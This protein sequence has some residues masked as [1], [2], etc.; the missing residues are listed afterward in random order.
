MK[1]FTA[2]PGTLLGG[3][4]FGRSSARPDRRSLRA[5]LFSSLNPRNYK[6]GLIASLLVAA[7]CFAPAMLAQSPPYYSDNAWVAY[8]AA[9]GSNDLIVTGGSPG[10][11]GAGYPIT[12]QSSPLTPALT[13][14]GGKLVL[15]YVANN[16]SDDLLV[17][18]NEA[19][20]TRVTGQ[21]SGHAP[22][23][24]VFNNKLVLAYVA[25]NGSDDLLVTTSTNGVNWTPSTPVTGQSSG[26]APAL[27][28]FDNKLVLAYVANNGSDD[29]LV[30]TSTN[31]VNWTP[32]TPVTGQ[33]SAQ[34]PSLT[35]FDNKLVL[36]YVAN[37]GS[38]DLLVTTSTNSV[39][40]TPSTPVTGQT[41]GLS[42]A[43][44]VIANPNVSY[45]QFTTFNLIMVYVADN[46]SDDLIVTTSA[47]GIHWTTGTR[48]TGQSSRATPAIV[49]TEQFND[50]IP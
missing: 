38:D 28:V 23:L 22:A 29:L 25:N 34:P 6:T 44:S 12:G 49:V 46:G 8:I 9:N 45:T 14:F 39:N 41:S 15:A 13:V 20:S 30:T 5:S 37:N 7:A 43:L 4:P 50:T 40:W 35:V 36:A 26:R 18:V 21:F 47:D 2:C 27:T 33:S 11:W 42:P 17:S 16:G 19:T 1:H 24:T 10:S 32:S 31:G 48:V 3:S